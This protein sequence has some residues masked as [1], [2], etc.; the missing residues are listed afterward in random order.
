MASYIPYQLNEASVRDANATPPT[1]GTRD[2][3]TKGVGICKVIMY[4]N[5]TKKQMVFLRLYAVA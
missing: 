5:Q 1:I 3:T 4:E 2:N